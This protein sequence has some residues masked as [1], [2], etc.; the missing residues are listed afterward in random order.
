MSLIF[1]NQ[2]Y[3][4][5]VLTHKTLPIYKTYAFDFYRSIAFDNKFYGKTV[6]ELHA[7]NLRVSRADN[8]YSNL[9]HGQRLSYWADSPQTA[10][11]EAKK[12][13][14]KNNLLT[15]WAYDDGSSFVPTKYPAQDLK[16]IDG[17]QLEF[18]TILKKLDR[19]ENLSR[20]EWK[21]IDSIAEE[22]PDCLVY[23][24]EARKGG[25]NFLF[26][27]NGFKKLSLREVWLRLGDEKGKN[28]NKIA[29]AG[30]SDYLP[31]ISAYG[32]MFLPIAKTS[33]DKSYRES[34]EYK[35]RLDVISHYIQ[36]TA[37]K[38]DD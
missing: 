22:D 21:T 24:S 9:F 3:G 27:E 38:N 4:A 36:R 33:F 30:T 7:G 13:G 26:F 23:A 6:S 17:F 14:A 37:G 29:C 31:L 2:D 18:N 25:R 20:S 10:R 11:A 35:L 1:P 28:H 12:W 15:F 5:E 16:I 19:H 32:E 8:R 34:D